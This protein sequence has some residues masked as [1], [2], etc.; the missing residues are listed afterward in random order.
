MSIETVKTCDRISK[1]SILTTD[2]NQQLNLNIWLM[3]TWPKIKTDLYKKL[4]V[5]GDPTLSIELCQEPAD[6]IPR[7]KKNKI[8]RR[9]LVRCSLICTSYFSHII[10][11]SF[12]QPKLIVIIF[13]ILIKQKT[14][15][16]SQ[17]TSKWTFFVM[18]FELKILISFWR[19]WVFFK[20]ATFLRTFW[21]TKVELENVWCITKICI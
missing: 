13:K 10:F 15:D 8:Y 21:R 6:S 9:P 20:E 14:R 18:N 5:N 4:T 3:L 16:K 2:L 7:A 12:G 19:L 17:F 11:L 1:W